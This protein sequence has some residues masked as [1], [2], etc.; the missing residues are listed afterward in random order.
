MFF[1]NKPS[2]PLVR[3]ET[4]LDFCSI[5]FATSMDT[6]LRS[7]VWV[8]RRGEVRGRGRG[9]AGIQNLKISVARAVRGETMEEER[10]GTR[11]VRRPTPVTHPTEMPCLAMV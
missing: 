1:L 2:M 3:P 9:G 11:A 4:D 7:G 10:T 6:S 5:I 8:G